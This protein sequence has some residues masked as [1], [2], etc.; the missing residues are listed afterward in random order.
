MPD[1]WSSLLL[2]ASHPVVLLRAKTGACQSHTPTY[3][4]QSG[5]DTA[6]W[7]WVGCGC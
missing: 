1:S 3:Y 2:D 5:P 6:G 4:L 7:L